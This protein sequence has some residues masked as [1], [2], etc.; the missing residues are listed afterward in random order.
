MI[1]VAHFGAC[2]FVSFLSLTAAL[3]LL[4]IFYSA[5]GSDLELKTM[6]KEAVLAGVASGVEALGLWVVLFLLHGGGRLM[7]VPGLIVVVLYRLGHLL[8]WSGHE[9]MGLLLFQVVLLAVGAALYYGHVGTAI[10]VLMGAGVLLWLV[11]S[12]AR[13]I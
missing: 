7:L 10:G 13:S 3:V 4:S 2:W 1:E 12:F 5:I 6:G 11:A 9:I 8:E